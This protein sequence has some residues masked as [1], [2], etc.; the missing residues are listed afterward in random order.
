M[1]HS[2]FLPWVVRL[3]TLSLTCLA[4]ST[5]ASS[6]H[7]G[8]FSHAVI[9]GEFE[10]TAKQGDYAARISSRFAVPDKILT[11]QNKL[12]PNRVLRSGEKVIVNNLHIV[13]PADGDNIV[14]NLPQRLLF[15]F[16][17]AVLN[18][19]YAVGLGK[20]DWPTPAGRFRIVNRQENKPWIVPRSIQEEMTRE[21]KTVLTEV[22][23]GPKNPLG[24]HWL[25]LSLP[26]IGIHGTIAPVSVYRYRSHGCIRMHPDDVQDLFG[27]A[28]VDME[29]RII[30]ATVLLAQLPDERIFLEVHNDIYKKGVNPLH[31]ARKL[32]EENGL[33]DRIDWDEAKNVIKRKDGIAI[34]ITRKQESIELGKND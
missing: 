28:S 34:D 25:G 32:A 14:I 12:V 9:G 13:P 21:G 5:Q 30:Y 1:T 20:R 23:P 22:P 33:V 19:A 26:G 11:A 24:K 6:N 18:N 2:R 27:K 29:G 7:P 4:A 16:E 8:I 3:L 17:D 15:Y 31:V 10:Y